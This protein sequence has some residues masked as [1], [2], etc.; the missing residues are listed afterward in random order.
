MHLPALREHSGPREGL[1]GIVA[2][3]VIHC[4]VFLLLA[5]APQAV[6]PPQPMP[7]GVV[8][9][10]LQGLAL[11]GG[12]GGGGGAASVVP[13]PVSR[14]QPQ[15]AP[16]AAPPVPV[17][18]M[19][20]AAVSVA[21]PVAARKVAVKAALR[22]EER[23]PHPDPSATNMPVPEKEARNTTATREAE[24]CDTVPVAADAA[25]SAGASGDAS[26]TAP[27]GVAGVGRGAGSGGP[28]SGTGAPAVGHPGGTPMAD[29]GE[30][31]RILAALTALVE[32]YKE[33][34]RAARRAGYQGTVVM[35]VKLRSDG[36]IDT[37]NVAACS[38]H[39]LLDRATEKAFARMEGV[40][41]ANVSL[42]GDMRVLVP[43]R[44]QLN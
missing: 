40:R 18:P 9:L 20:P 6:R 12:G 31:Q 26:G 5:M 14:P 38:A 17:K 10:D 2:S 30:T 25:A 37:W 32:R 33:Y 4:G 1:G 27:G 23:K 44:Y 3:L 43:V 7:L 29:A 11:P 42:P 13:Q 36:A 8:M 28:G 35:A 39:A 15:A 24:F 34:P 16:P 41:V 21:K 22:P 19:A